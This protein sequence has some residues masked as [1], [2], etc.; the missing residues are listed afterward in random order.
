MVSMYRPDSKARDGSTCIRSPMTY[1]T[2]DAKDNAANGAFRRKVQ[3]EMEPAR[4]R[5]NDESLDS[6]E[7]REPASN[8]T[9]TAGLY[10]SSF[11]IV[12]MPTHR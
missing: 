4:G 2:W 3:P 10:D 9:S 11:D 8:W 12:D 1:P 7:A 6:V 5:A